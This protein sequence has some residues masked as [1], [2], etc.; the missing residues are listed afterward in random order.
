ML[1]RSSEATNVFNSRLVQVIPYLDA[2]KR[3]WQD[4]SLGFTLMHNATIYKTEPKIWF[5]YLLDLDALYYIPYRGVIITLWNGEQKLEN[6][7]VRTSSDLWPFSQDLCQ[8]S[9]GSQSPRRFPYVPRILR[10]TWI[11]ALFCAIQRRGKGVISR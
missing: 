7:S 9:I 8:A 2:R 5:A 10:S 6:L 1:F 11:N 3:S 4:V